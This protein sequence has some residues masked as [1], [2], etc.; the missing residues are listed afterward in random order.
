MYGNAWAKKWEWVVL[1]AGLGE[2]CWELARGSHGLG[3]LLEG[4]L[5]LKRQ[6]LGGGEK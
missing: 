2:E 6:K 5:G 4:K 3:L 1:G